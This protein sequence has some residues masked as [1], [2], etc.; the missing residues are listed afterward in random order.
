MRTK[1]FLSSLILAI[2]G[3][4]GGAS[5]DEDGSL[6]G[7]MWIVIIGVVVAV[8]SGIMQSSAE[9]QKKREKAAADREKRLARETE[10]K[11]RFEEWSSKYISE[12]GIPDKTII[13][14]PN[15]E[16][17]II[18]VH[19]GKRQVYLKGKMYDFKDF[20]N[21][22]FTDSPIIIKGKTTATTKSSTGST[23]GRAI[24]GDVIA[25]PAGAIIGGT[26]GKKT[27]EFQHENDRVIHD[28][29]VVV[30]VNSISTPIVRINTGAD[31]KT[32]NEIVGLINVIIAR[33]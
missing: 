24:V 25:G 18:H 29:T 8:I 2:F 20:I 1:I 5:V 30:N 27:T 9:D 17:E 12:N 6:S 23:V 15:D 14:K 4:L 32:T 10:Q 33:R 26:T 16:M 28:Y 31:G 21:V 19:E 13:V 7:W 22:T 3:L 11:A